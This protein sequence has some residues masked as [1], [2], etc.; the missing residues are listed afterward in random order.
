M[1]GCQI[2]Y[3]VPGSNLVRNKLKTFFDDHLEVDKAHIK[4]PFN[5]TGTFSFKVTQNGNQITSESVNI[6]VGTS[7]KLSFQA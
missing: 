5:F 4:G 6:N 7:F 2:E 1:P 3:N